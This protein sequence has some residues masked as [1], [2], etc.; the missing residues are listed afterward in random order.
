MICMGEYITSESAPPACPSS[1][2]F[3]F[4]S[5]IEIIAKGGKNNL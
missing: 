2:C 3:L 4:D 5:D 1:G